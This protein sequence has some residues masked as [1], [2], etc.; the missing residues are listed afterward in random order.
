MEDLNGKTAVVTGGASGIGSA[1]AERFAAEGMRLVLADVEPDALEGAVKR[2]S[3]TGAEVLA[4][5][6]DVADAVAVDTLAEATFDRFGTAHVVCNNAGVVVGGPGWEIPLAEWEWILGVNLWGVIHGIRSFVPRLVEQG[7]GHVVNTAS[8]AGL[9]PLPFSAPY[10]ATKHAVVG[11]SASLFHELALSGSPVGVTVLCPGFLSTNLL[12]AARNWPDRLGPR[13]NV[14][15]DPM[16]Q[17]MMSVA[18]SMMDAGPPLSV[19]TEK[20]VDAIKKRQFLV[21]TDER[22]ANNFAASRVEEVGGAEPA[23][24]DLAN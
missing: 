6:T 24:P 12:D 7:E 23:F 10:T 15:D 14:D 9:G 4:V 11:I 16:A 13:R 8:I 21:T 2:L 18:Q 22:L 20:V 3:D 19:L 1:M 5:P 17:F